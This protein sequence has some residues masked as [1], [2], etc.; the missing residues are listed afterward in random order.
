MSHL[1]GVAW[2]NTQ[3]KFIQD[4]KFGN[5]FMPDNSFNLEDP[6][7]PRLIDYWTSCSLDNKTKYENSPNNEYEIGPRRNENDLNPGKY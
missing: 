1:H 6:D 3:S 5:C 4:N 7:L 2:F